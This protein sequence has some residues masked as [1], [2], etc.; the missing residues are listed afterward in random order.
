MFRRGRN[1]THHL[2]SSHLPST[3]WARHPRD[4]TYIFWPPFCISPAN[5]YYLHL[6]GKNLRPENLSNSHTAPPRDGKIWIKTWCWNTLSCLAARSTVMLL[7]LSQNR[8]VPRSLSGVT[9]KLQ[10]CI[11]IFILNVKAFIFAGSRSNVNYHLIIARWDLGCC[12]GVEFA[13][14]FQ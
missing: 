3:K 7:N 13:N 6:I 8:Q 4:L 9:I 10:S 11:S 1:H 5:K 2:N 12:W 14:I